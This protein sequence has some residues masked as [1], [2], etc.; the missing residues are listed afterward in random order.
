MSS[1]TIFITGASSGIGLATA[2]LFY[3]EGWNVV[4]AMRSPDKAPTELSSLDTS[5]LLIT[6]CDV[7]DLPSIQAAVAATVE[8]FGKVNWVVNN[9][10]F[11][12]LGVFEA[13]PRE[14]VLEQINTNVIGLMDVTR[15]FLPHLRH[16]ATS[17]KNSALGIINISSG[18]GIYSLPMGSLYSSS[19]YAVEG[20]TEALSYELASQNISTK[21]VIPHG[22]ISQTSLMQRSMQ[23]SGQVDAEVNKLYK[24]YIGKTMATFTRMV[25]AITTS[26]HDVA[27]TIYEAATD[28]TDKFRY[29]IGDDYRGFL[30][31]KYGEK[32][33]KTD[34]EYIA[35]MR[36]YFE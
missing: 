30:T 20:F 14:K 34:E 35:S 4:A 5:R 11:A 3:T 2:V 19:K 13:T 16:S 7:L 1:K 21:L 18:A 28:G 10:G 24:E 29:F 6:E 22:G 25:N 8:R 23:E 33:T 12:L 15:A 26:S 32:G 9:A 36:K 27:K 17:E 31:A